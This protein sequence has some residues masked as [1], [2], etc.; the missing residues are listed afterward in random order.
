VRSPTLD[1]LPPP[2]AGATGW[3]WTEDSP[4]CLDA[5]PDG[6]RWPR[7]SVVTPSYN[8]GRFIEETI[9]SVLLQGYPEL[10]YIIM[11]GGSTDGSVDVIRRYEPWLTYWVS[12]A[13]RGQSHAIN[14]GWTRATGEVLAYINTDDCYLPGAV[15]TA[16]A[17][18]SLR[19]DVAMVYGNASIVDEGGKELSSWKARPFDLKTMLVSGSV[20]PQPATFFSRAVVDKLGYL[21]EKRIMIMDYE[22]C[23]RIGMDHQTVCLAHTL[24]R[25]RAHEQSKTWLHFETTAHEL[26][27]F[28]RSFPSERMAGRD[29]NAIRNGTLSRVHYEWALQYLL[30]DRRGTQALK[31][32]LMSIRL[33]PGF[34]LRRPMLTAHIA[35][36]V[37]LRY[38]RPRRSSQ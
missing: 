23:T 28:V 17:E 36:E 10:E 13:D 32:L 38:L 25:F 35:K 4:R 37:L 11:D 30:R 22:L 14:K 33:H 12:E 26:M 19:P 18:F 16:A 27:D 8:Q 31:Q 3:P 20:V 2:P 1:Q 24:A 7:V 29:W 5:R 15:A 9:R 6:G 34:A 21:N